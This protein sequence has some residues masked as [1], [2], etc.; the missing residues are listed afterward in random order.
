MSPLDP[1]PR[2]GGA[3]ANASD[4]TVHA[5]LSASA[6]TGKTMVLTSR[7]L[8]LLLRG[9][10]PGAILGLTFTKAAAAEMANRI[11]ARLARW[12]RM[13][14]QHLRADLA[15]LGERTDPDTIK[16]ARQLFARLL[17]T[18][19][20]LR[21]QTIHA[22]SQSLLASFPAE[23]GIA[24][25]FEAIDERA[26]DRLV[27]EVLADLASEAAAAA[28]PGDKRFLADLEALSLRLGQ[29]GATAFLKSC[30]A[31]PRGFAR[32][33]E[34]GA[35]EPWLRELSGLPREGDAAAILG[36]ALA[37]ID[38]RLF[39]RLIAANRA[40]GSGKKATSIVANLS[41]FRA[42]APAQRVELLAG[43]GANIV[44]ADGEVCKVY[45]KQEAADPDYAQLAQDF[46]D[47]WLPL[48]RLPD[49]L[50]YLA[51]LAAALRAG[52]RFAARYGQVKQARGLADFTDLIE[53]TLE[54]LDQPG[55]GDWIRFK[56][57][58]RIDHVLIDE[59]Q[60]TNPA[61]W[62]IIDA[63]VEEFFHGN[64]ET[65]ERFRTLFMVGD[66]KQA[67]YSFQGSE[68]EQFI[69]SRDRYRRLAEGAQA[70]ARDERPRRFEDLSVSTS[71]RSAPAVLALVD[72][73]IETVGPEAMGL[74]AAPPRHA[75]APHRAE[76]FGSV[77][78][79]PAFD[80]DEEAGAGSGAGEQ[81]AGEENWLDLRDRHYARTLAEEVKALV[82]TG[83][84]PGDILILLRRRSEL[85]SLI[86]ARLFAAGVPV[87]GVDRLFLS[88]PLA[89]QDLLAAMRFAAQPGD[90]LSL[91]C[92]LVGPLVGWSQ[93]QLEALAIERDT[94][95]LWDSLRRRED[96]P[97]KAARAVLDELLAMA[98]FTGPGAFLEAILS[99]PMD[100]RRKLM[101]R[102]G[103]DARDP[104]EELLNAA[105]D[106]ERNDSGS[107][108]HFLAR[109]EADDSEVKR[110]AGGKG[111]EV[112]VMTV[113]GAK[114]LE[115]PVVI[116]ADA[117]WDPARGGTRPTVTLPLDDLGEM[118]LLQPRKDE[119]GPPFAAAL[120]ALEAREREEHWR[121]LYVALTRAEERLIIAGP[122]P[123][124][125]RKGEG[126]EPLPEACWHVAVARALATLDSAPLERDWARTDGL[127]YFTG[128][129]R[130]RPARALP[131]AGRQCE[132]P[133]WARRPAPA[134]ARPPRPLSPSAIEGVEDI[135][136]PPA[137]PDQR[138]AARRGIL[139]HALLE[140]LPGVPA[141]ARAAT[142]QRWLT[143]SHGV[144][145]A[146]AE[147]LATAALGV[148]E[149]PEHAALFGDN[150]LAEAP[151]AATL[152][153]GRVIAGTVDRLLVEPDRVLVVDFKTGRRVPEDAAAVPEAYRR[154][155]AA[156]VAALEVIFPGRR[157]ESALL[158][159]AGPRL[160]VLP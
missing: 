64:A 106:F 78:L 9:V 99:G 32:L 148:I 124:K 30:A 145:A 40:W 151:L 159:T 27:T 141:E 121:L 115:A 96:A 50:G 93:E 136:F 158:Y 16:R 3:Q 120:E 77:E 95:R 58:A 21:I 157:I 82:D 1:L 90:D 67:I 70:A 33:S 135:A 22:F 85:A 127:V 130:P 117:T 108:D 74:P 37:T 118:P 100:G 76:H 31:Y 114:G 132:L 13:D 129:P 59:A 101:A 137:T 15:N 143:T 122:R 63:M 111:A 140:R 62:R 87:A 38:D 75:V 48:V 45:A 51:A 52:A 6:G 97:A 53:W 105:L 147:A 4:P 138:D 102:L 110:E 23:A 153:D 19:G 112:R 7:V 155:M 71:F 25:G 35:I 14:E 131:G 43:L 65:E 83:T 61:Q 73:V 107:L 154:Q 152:P 149:A 17:D 29:D 2:L 94:P 18:P 8:R 123:R 26:A 142:A 84:A 88:R 68:P 10:S 28:L 146:E 20:G 86:V 60:D 126:L 41:A 134:E 133:E 72:R 113:H 91:A 46:A 44:K 36:T 39:E 160:L 47:W 116:L 98:D 56:L 24:P 103:H 139:I 156:Y 79:W 54:L 11:G 55:I 69:A 119:R 150:A 80:F 42:A 89:V 81:D 128:R 5:A 49:R 109:I 57:D 12:V 92:L 104:I 144:A 66:F 34:K 125:R